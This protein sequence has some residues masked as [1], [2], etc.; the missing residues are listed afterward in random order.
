MFWSITFNRNGFDIEKVTIKT[1]KQEE[2][3]HKL[4]ENVKVLLD[5]VYTFNKN[6]H[7]CCAIAYC[8]FL[9][10]HQEIRL[11]KWKDFSTDLKTSHLGGNKVKSKRN[12][13]VPVPDY[14]RNLLMRSEPDDNI[15]SNK[16]KPYNNDY[17]K[18][19]FKQLNPKV[20]KDHS[21]LLCT[22]ES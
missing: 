21:T 18:M 11:L 2:V 22:Q 6:L 4:I 17:F 8:C 16:I 10:S 1:R 14:M 12:R 5:K 3:L 19:L 7:L 20:D 9:R 15:F 13:W